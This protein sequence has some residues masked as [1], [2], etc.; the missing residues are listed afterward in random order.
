ML[1]VCDVFADDFDVKFNNSKSVAMR[2]LAILKDAFHYK[3]DGKDIRYVNELKY[4]GGCC[5]IRAKYLK[6]SVE[7]L[8]LKFYRMFNCVYS[9]SKATN[10]EMVTVQL[11]KLYCL[12]FMMYSVDAVSISSANIR[13]PENCI[14]RAMYRAFGACGSSLESLKCWTC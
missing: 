6:L 8:I 14:N 3:I 13:I 12:P 5:V 4:M 7:H 10:S 1:H 2:K 9:K 11:L